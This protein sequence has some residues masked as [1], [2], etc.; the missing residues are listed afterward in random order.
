[1]LGLV[2]PL[3]YSF[4]LIQSRVLRFSKHLDYAL[5]SKL[6]RL[7]PLSLSMILVPIVVVTTTIII[8]PINIICP[9]DDSDSNRNLATKGSAENW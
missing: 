3:T 6:T 5:G 2:K 9:S 8:T 1:M 4:L 7:K